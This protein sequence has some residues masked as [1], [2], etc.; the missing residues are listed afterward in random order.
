MP[1]TPNSTE[2]YHVFLASP[3]DM[4]TERKAVRGFFD[5]Y[6]HTQAEL[7][8]LR[9]QVLD[10]ESYASTGIGRTQ[11]LITEQ[12]LHKYRDSLAL[13]ICLLGQRF[14]APTGTHES[15]T[16]EEFDTALKIRGENDGWPEIKFFFREGWG[17][18]GAPTDDDA[19][20]EALAQKRKVTAFRKRLGKQG[21]A[22]SLYATFEQ[23][24]DCSTTT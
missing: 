7:R 17:Q 8:G 9:F 3:G 15:G 5:A 2:T 16:V 14:G 6:N 4:E 21:P 18:E 10:W 1:L 20:E 11:A 22:Q 23:T 24:R 19:L 13:V 12:T